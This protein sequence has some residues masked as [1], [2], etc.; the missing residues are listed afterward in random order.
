MVKIETRTSFDQFIVFN[1]AIGVNQANDEAGNEAT[2][3]EIGANGEASYN[4]KTKEAQIYLKAHL[5]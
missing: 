5:I 2:I 3:I 4:A 1:R